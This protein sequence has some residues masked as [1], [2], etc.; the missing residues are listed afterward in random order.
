MKIEFLAAGWQ[1]RLVVFLSKHKDEVY[2]TLELSRILKV[3]YYTLWNLRGHKLVPVKGVS[4][5]RIGKL[6]YWGHPD[7]IKALKKSCARQMS[8]V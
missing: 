5:Y 7:A 4:F 2:T 1:P 6:L 8:R 3:G